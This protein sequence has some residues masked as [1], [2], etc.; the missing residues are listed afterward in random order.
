MGGVDLV[1]VHGVGGPL[2]HWQDDLPATVCTVVNS[3][4]ADLLIP[5]TSSRSRSELL[6]TRAVGGHNRRFMQASARRRQSLIDIVDSC[7]RGPGGTD[8]ARRLRPPVWLSAS[9]LLITELP[10]VGD[11]VRYRRDAQARLAAAHRV[12]AAVRSCSNP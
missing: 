12:A 1:Y 9:S 8:G 7:A 2:S 6:R 10:F 11:A 5:G 4:Y 3:T